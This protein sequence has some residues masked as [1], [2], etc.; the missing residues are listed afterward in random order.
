MIVMSGFR[1]DVQGPD[2]G[3]LATIVAGG[4]FL[5]FFIVAIRIMIRSTNKV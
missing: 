5:V 1:G 2:H 4:I 3:W